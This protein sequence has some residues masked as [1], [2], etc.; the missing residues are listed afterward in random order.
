M[1]R[2]I[3][4]PNN[5]KCG[6]GRH[7]LGSDSYNK[8]LKAASGHSV[9]GAVNNAVSSLP[10]AAAPHPRN[11][12]EEL[13]GALDCLRGC[14]S[15]LPP[16]SYVGDMTFDNDEIQG[17]IDAGSA[18]HMKAEREQM[19]KSRIRCN[20]DDVAQEIGFEGPDDDL[21]ALADMVLMTRNRTSCRLS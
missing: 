18:S 11:R 13:L 6:F 8:C 1:A 20:L 14:D 19:L 17:I 4:C 7:I 10:P 15:Y 12:T 3:D 2:F 16:R 21:D 5:G 9:R